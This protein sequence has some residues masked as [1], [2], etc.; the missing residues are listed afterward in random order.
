MVQPMADFCSS[1]NPPGSVGISEGLPAP[2]SSVRARTRSS[3]S[4]NHKDGS[5]V[6]VFLRNQTA[7][8]AGV[9]SSKD[10]E[11]GNFAWPL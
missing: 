5:V 7:N 6:L 9:C 10:S 1:S 2:P 3:S 4:I 11:V 8:P